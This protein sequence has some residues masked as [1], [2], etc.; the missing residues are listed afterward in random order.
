MH[1]Y[2]A[3]SKLATG[4]HGVDSY[5]RACDAVMRQDARLY[6]PWAQEIASQRFRFGQSG[7]TYWTG[8]L[9][10]GKAMGASESQSDILIGVTYGCRVEMPGRD[11]P[12]KGIFVGEDG[13]A[14]LGVDNGALFSEWIGLI[15]R[16]FFS[17]A[18]GLFELAEHEGHT[19]RLWEQAVWVC[20]DGLG[21]GI[22]LRAG[23]RGATGA[24]SVLG[25]QGS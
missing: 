11:R 14:E 4:Q 20:G 21:R 12:W 18:A 10:R 13:M 2:R 23:T 17:P 3:G 25:I 7:E 16:E 9:P 22:S 19:I 5:G 1:S 6:G 8:A 15:V 24:D